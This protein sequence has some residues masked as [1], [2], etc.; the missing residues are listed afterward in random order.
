VRFPVTGPVRYTMTAKQ[1]VELCSLMRP[2][3]VLPIHYEGWTHFR[4]GRAA[5][6]RAFAEAPQDIRR[7]VRWLPLGHSAELVV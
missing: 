7:L 1:A 5:I 3:A 2:N 6:E 4:Q